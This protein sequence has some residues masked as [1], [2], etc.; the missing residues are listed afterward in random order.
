MAGVLPWS[1]SSLSAF[2]TCPRRYHLTRI[3]K[4][5]TEKQTEATIWGNQVHKALED[6]VAGTKALDQQFTKYQPIVDKVRAVNAKKLTENKF[7]IT[8]GFKPTTFFAKDVWF[9][10]VIDLTLLKPKVAHVW[11][12]KTGKVKSDGDQLKLFA[13]STFAAYPY[14]EKVKTS[15]IWLAYDK[16]TS[17]EFTKDDVPGIWQEFLPRVGRMEQALADDKWL[18]NPSGLCKAHCSVGK[19]LCDFCGS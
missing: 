4:V 19:K 5:V 10:G 1:Y 17:A 6:A 11:D 15:Y 3:A 16:T 13:A 8:A 18:P 7:G 9:R 12:Y 2:E 14:L